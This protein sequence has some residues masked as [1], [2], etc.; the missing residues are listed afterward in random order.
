MA[1]RKVTSSRRRRSA[2]AGSWLALVAATT[3]GDGVD[4]LRAEVRADGLTDG[5][6]RLVVQSYDG[7]DGR[8]PG[9]RARPVGSA[10]RAVTADQLRAGVQISV[11]E[12]RERAEARVAERPLV[13]AWI[14]AGG[15]DL[16]FDGR[17]ARPRPG[18]VYG[19]VK[20]ASRQDAVQKISLNRTVAA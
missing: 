1:R 6:Y 12:V 14:E 16:E 10:Q 8:V 20:R 2:A 7:I 4:T 13:V 5:D 9:Q 17:T 15:P 19:V 18:S 11:L 3:L